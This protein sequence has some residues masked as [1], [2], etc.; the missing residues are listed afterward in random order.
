MNQASRVIHYIYNYGF[1]RTLFKIMGRSNMVLFKPV[2]I[3]KEP[4]IA[5]I[6]CGQ[7][8]FSTIAYFLSRSWTQRIKY[9]FDIEKTRE[10]RLARVY[11]LVNDPGSVSTIINDP[12]ISLVYIASNHASHTAYALEVLES[13]KNV[14]I[15][16]PISVEMTE[17]RKLRSAMEVSSG[18]VYIGYNRPHSA[19]VR[20][21]KEWFYSTN[22][23]ALKTK[24]TF[25]AF[26]SAHVIDADHWYR[27]VDEGT[28]ICGNVGHWIDLYIH[29][30][31][32]RGELPSSYEIAI[33]SADPVVPDDDINLSIVSANGDLA[34]ITV[35]SRSEPPLGI[36]ETISLQFGNV[37]GSVQDFKKTHAWVGTT[38]KTFKTRFKDVGHQRSVNQPFN[39]VYRNQKE[40][41]IST[42]IMLVAATMVKEGVSTRSVMID[43]VK[44]DK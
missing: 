24:L 16:K 1:L 43:H 19:H 22:Q 21:L 9:C 12:D 28:R 39:S 34:S 2:Y 7:F 42:E 30:L 37:I 4:F 8:Q 15:E 35:T 14:Y 11:G 17:F 10:R 36:E 5:L 41:L 31:G 27:Y 26:V 23:D 13:G 3:R 32:W 33:S 18:K 44:L 40:W 6:G 29:I 20:K 25:N 38:K